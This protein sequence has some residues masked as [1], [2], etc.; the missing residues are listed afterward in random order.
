MDYELSAG[1]VARRLGVTIE[2]VRKWT[3]Q[4]RL[5]CIRTVG[6]HRR[7]AAVEV[8]RLIGQT[9]RTEDGAA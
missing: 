1:D 6:G 4:G 2:T 9:T 8:E 7:Y 5:D 3:A